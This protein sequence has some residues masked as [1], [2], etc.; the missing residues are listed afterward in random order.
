MIRRYHNKAAIR[1]QRQLLCKYCHESDTTVT[2]E[3]D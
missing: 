3:S 2:Y 1:I